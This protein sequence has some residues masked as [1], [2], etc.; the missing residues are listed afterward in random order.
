MGSVGAAGSD[1]FGQ[2][3][4]L[5]SPRGARGDSVTLRL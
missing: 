4:S 1:E 2:R 5:V 3:S